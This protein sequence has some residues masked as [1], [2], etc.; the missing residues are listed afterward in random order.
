[1]RRDVSPAAI[2]RWSFKCR[3]DIT[4]LLALVGVTAGEAGSLIWVLR[5]SDMVVTGRLVFLLAAVT[6]VLAFNKKL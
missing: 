6:A 1:M 3:C 5:G 4:G 2:S